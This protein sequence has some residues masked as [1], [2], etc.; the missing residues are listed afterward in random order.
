MLKAEASQQKERRREARGWERDD[1][2]LDHPATTFF[3]GEYTVAKITPVE[4]TA[5]VAQ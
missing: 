2:L 4:E 5:A 1:D 3:V